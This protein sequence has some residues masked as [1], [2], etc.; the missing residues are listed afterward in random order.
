MQSSYIYLGFYVN[1]TIVSK[2]KIDVNL[3][4]ANRDCEKWQ[5]SSSTEQDIEFYNQNE[6]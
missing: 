1:N 2:F 3:L 6:C 4:R 5:S